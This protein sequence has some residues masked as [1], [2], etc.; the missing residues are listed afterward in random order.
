[1]PID[2]VSAYPSALYT[3]TPVAGLQACL[4]L[5]NAACAFV[6]Y[7]YDSSNCTVVNPDVGSAT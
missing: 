7:D 2:R 4:D 6:N 5:C 3:V 1:M